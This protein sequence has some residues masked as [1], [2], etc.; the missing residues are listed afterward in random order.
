MS[1]TTT[2]LIAVAIVGGLFFLGTVA[3]VVAVGLGAKESSAEQAGR[4]SDPKSKTST[5]DVSTLAKVHPDT[6][7]KIQNHRF[8]KKPLTQTKVAELLGVIVNSNKGHVIYGNRTGDYRR[9]NNDKTAAEIQKTKDDQFIGDWIAD[10][11][12]AYVIAIRHFKDRPSTE[13]AAE[14]MLLSLDHA[15]FRFGPGKP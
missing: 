13:E 9:E 4:G 14:Y 11:G 8:W 2:G 10:N 5:A 12:A 15:E 1:K 6:L 3:V 7:R